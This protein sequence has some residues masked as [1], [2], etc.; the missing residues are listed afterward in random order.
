[1]KNL[2]LGLLILSSALSYADNDNKCKNHQHITTLKYKKNISEID[3][4]L[5]KKYTKQVS[6][7][8]NEYVTNSLGCDTETFTNSS[9]STKSGTKFQKEYNI[10]GTYSCPESYKLIVSASH[11]SIRGYGDITV[12]L[13]VLKSESLDL[14]FEEEFILD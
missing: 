7:L 14:I 2:L 12:K 6:N 10:K 9:F 8:L 11:D 5:Y 13:K 4:F 3:G 1:M